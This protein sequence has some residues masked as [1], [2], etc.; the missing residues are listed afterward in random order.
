MWNEL[1]SFPYG[2]LLVAAASVAA[3]LVATRWGAGWLAWLVG[4]AGPFCIAIA[5]YLWP[6][7]FLADE[8]LADYGAWVFIFILAGTAAGLVANALAAAAVWTWRR[9]RRTP[10]GQ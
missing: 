5:L 9:L 8:A 3:L 2:P 7:L 10:A 1:L 4:I 6:L